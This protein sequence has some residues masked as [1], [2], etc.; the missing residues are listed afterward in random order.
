M[1]LVFIFTVDKQVPVH[2]KIQYVE[3]RNLLSNM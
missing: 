1:V 3:I 2:L